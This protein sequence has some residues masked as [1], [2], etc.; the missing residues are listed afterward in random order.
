MRFWIFVTLCRNK[1]SVKIN[2]WSRIIVNGRAFCYRFCLELGVGG[3]FF[4]KTPKIDSHANVTSILLLLLYFTPTR[5]HNHARDFLLPTNHQ[6]KRTV[7]NDQKHCEPSID[8]LYDPT[9]HVTV[10]TVSYIVFLSVHNHSLSAFP[11]K[12]KNPNQSIKI[13][14][15][16]KSK[17][18][19]FKSD[20]ISGPWLTSHMRTPPSEPSK[21]PLWS[22]VLHN[23]RSRSYLFKLLC[24]LVS[25]SLQHLWSCESYDP[26]LY[27]ATDTPPQ[28][29]WK[30]PK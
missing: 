25:L 20:S 5:A 30:G 23:L 14:K 12:Q 6:T 21:L 4:C 9:R 24:F 27:F 2:E 26:T 29:H 15:K 3:K 13:K 10:Y 8:W 28:L 17:P 16:K 18:V 1:M 11:T 22:T 19:N 7:I